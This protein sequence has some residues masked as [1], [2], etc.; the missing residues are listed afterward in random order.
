MAEVNRGR[1]LSVFAVL[2]GI[3]L[4][5]YAA[6]IW[7]M[8]RYALVMGCAYAAYVILNLI[9]FTFTGQRPPG[10]GYVLFGIVYADIAIGVSSGAA[11]LL[12]QR[13]AALT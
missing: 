5:F 4:A 8:R 10:V 2:F 6:G 12:G 7:R 13:R 11:Y 1:A 3:Y 9:L